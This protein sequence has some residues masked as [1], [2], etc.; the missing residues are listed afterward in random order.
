LFIGEERVVD[1]DLA[2]GMIE[3]SGAIALSP[4][5]HAIRV[6]Y[7][8]GAGDFGL[9]VSYEGPGLARQ[10]IPPAA[11]FHQKTAEP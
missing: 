9:E 8:Q 2:H 5:K 6:L 7:L 3:R 11:L 1:N 4:G 10:P